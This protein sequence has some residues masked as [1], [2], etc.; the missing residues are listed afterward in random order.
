MS[1]WHSIRRGQFRRPPT[2]WWCALMLMAVMGSLAAQD[3][4]PA[5]A[6]DVVQVLRDIEDLQPKLP[7]DRLDPAAIVAAVGVEPAR[8]MAWVRDHTRPIA[9]SGSLRGASGVLMDRAGNSLDRSL[10]LARLLHNAGYEARI[11]NAALPP[12]EVTR[13]LAEYPRP[14]EAAT[15]PAADSQALADL[16]SDADALA[17]MI[18]QKVGAL[19]R[20]ASEVDPTHYWVQFQDGRAWVDLDPTLPEAHKRRAEPQGAP[21]IP[22]PATGGIDPAAKLNHHVT[23]TLRVERW[24]AGKLV[25]VPLLSL[26]YDPIRSPLAATTMTFA[27]V[28]QRSAKALQR[29]FKTGAQLRQKLLAESAWS[30]VIV[31]GVNAGRMA[32]V[33]NDAGIVSDLPKTFG[34][35]ELGNIA[36]SG[37]GGL[38]GLGGADE[39]AEPPTVLTALVADYQLS[40]PGKPVR[41]IRRFV[42]DSIGPEARQAAASKP[43]ERPRWTEPQRL[44]RGAELAAISD[45][46][47]AFASVPTDVYVHRFAQRVI[48][49]KPAALKAAQGAVDAPTLEQLA[50]GRSFRT[51]ELYAASRNSAMD[52]M[53]AIAEPQIYR[54]V[55]RY[56]PNSDARELDVQVVSDLAWN[57]LATVRADVSATAVVRQGV[58]DTLQ[59][60]VVVLRDTPPEPGEATSAL[61]KEAAK[62]GIETV[63]FRDAG[64]TALAV[65]PGPAR[66]RM[67]LDLQ[68]GQLVVTPARPVTVQGIPRTGWWRVD[69]ATEH[70]VGVM[71]TGMLQDT[72]EYTTTSEVNGVR[73]MHFHRMRVGP[74]AREWAQHMLRQRG[75]VQ[76]S[77]N[78]WINLLRY[79]QQSV[80]QFGRLPPW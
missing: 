30:P 3:T 15:E 59:E 40:V 64:D 72:I 34:P 26:G 68:A 14:A 73:I 37:F 1:S 67:Q 35:G 13:L 46:L 8:L 10:L 23:L 6:D 11:V 63:V 52:P 62:Q 42:F 12:E 21:L 70:T 47:V 56:L 78:Q 43:L 45:T 51:L 20:A 31:S 80:N 65:F 75:A 76:T 17:K 25:E 29:D 24:E 53:L 38:G 71:D 36:R 54:R 44:E 79:A 9:Y 27:P 2:W 18:V 69:P 57:R 55:I 48:D 49:S 41:H 28:D 66:A 74:A 39:A 33:F 50:Q 32:R 58:L 7:R 77:W 60:A 19:N 16:K 5:S 22:D 61:L 4:A